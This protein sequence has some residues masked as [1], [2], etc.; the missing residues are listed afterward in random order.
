MD[1]KRVVLM[2]IAFWCLMLGVRASP[3]QGTPN[4]VFEYE[5]GLTP[6]EVVDFEAMRASVRP[7]K[8]GDRRSTTLAAQGNR[9]IATV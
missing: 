4:T 6:A 3:A 7:F 8:R 2:I 1:S 5:R 9:P